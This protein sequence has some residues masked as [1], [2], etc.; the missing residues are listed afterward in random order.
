M[1]VFIDAD[2]CP[3][4]KETELICQKYSINLA[5]MCDTN[6]ILNC[7]YGKVITVGAG[8]DAV[9]FEL[10]NRC[11]PGD[12]VI[13]Q[14]YGVAA[15]ALSRK[16]RCLNQNGLI[17]TDDNISQLLYSRYVTKKIRSSSSKHHLKG[18]A[19]RKQSDDESFRKSFLKLIE[20]S[21]KEQR[22]YQNNK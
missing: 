20:I 17:Y 11:K 19:K 14:D 4:V 12:I 13:T 18:P 2:G 22:V 5:V 6:H 21:I 9:D 8:A 1:T 3:V 10:I 7:N 16:C 15:M